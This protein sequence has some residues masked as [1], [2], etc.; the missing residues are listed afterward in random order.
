MSGRRDVPRTAAVL[1]I[2]SALIYLI[3]EALAAAAFPGYS[4][5]TNYISDLGVPEVGDFQGRAI[6]SPLH[7]VMNV[8]FVGSGILFLLAA[9]IAVRASTAGPR[10]IF[11]A[12]AVTYAAGIT[13]VGLFHGSQASAD[14]GSDVLHVAGA[15]MAIVGGNLAAISG[16]ATLR[17]G[18][19]PPGYRHV[20]IVLGAVGIVGLVMLQIDSRTT[21]VDIL[22]D[23]VWERVA[24][25][26]VTAWQ[27]LT[28]L[29]LLTRSRRDRLAQGSYSVAPRG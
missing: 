16:G 6:D 19:I 27:L 11:L 9:T 17:G 24:V 2:A 26:T 10:R 23:G 14:D 29:V 7:P 28:G 13:L 12:C 21:V 25:Y 18:G 3:A 20:S 22:P 15:A 1:W 8:G 5:A 4:Y